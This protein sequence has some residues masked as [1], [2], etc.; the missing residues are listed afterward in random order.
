MPL[1][2]LFCSARSICAGL[3]LS[4]SCSRGIS[5]SLG[6]TPTTRN[7]VAVNLDGLIHRSR[8]AV[9]PAQHSPSRYGCRG[10]LGG[11]FR[12]KFRPAIDTNTA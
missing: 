2:T 12:V 3:E 5:K 10:T 4:V 6:S 7:R 1:F 8:V 11:L 9:K